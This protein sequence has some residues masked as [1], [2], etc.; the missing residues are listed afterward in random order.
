MPPKAA[1]KRAAPPAERQSKR[2]KTS[3]AAPTQPAENAPS[4]SN[5]KRWAQVSAS[6]NADDDF[7][8]A[9]QDASRANA[10]ICICKPPFIDRNG[11]DDE[12]DEE[13][14]KEDDEDDE[15]NTAKAPHG[16][17]KPKC[18]GGKKCSV[19][20]PLLPQ[21]IRMCRTGFLICMGLSLMTTPYEMIPTTKY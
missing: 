19:G 11:D 1:S 16:G 10:Y 2:A 18:D 20:D 5:S 17:D 12:E 7:R 15:D 3:V 13:T 9:V 14:D 8:L 4:P 21:R 6:R